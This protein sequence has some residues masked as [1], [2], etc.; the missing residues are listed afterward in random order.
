MD[1]SHSNHHLVAATTSALGTGYLMY[2]S[3]SKSNVADIT[4]NE[5]GAPTT[6]E[7]RVEGQYKGHEDNGQGD[8]PV[9]KFPD[10]EKSS[11]QP[12][13]YSTGREL[14]IQ[15]ECTDLL[16]AFS[17]EIQAVQEHLE[18]LEPVESETD[19]EATELVEE[20]N[21]ENLLKIMKNIELPREELVEDSIEVV[22]ESNR[23]VIN[24]S[25]TLRVNKRSH[26]VPLFALT[27]YGP[28]FPLEK[29]TAF[30]TY[31]SY[32]RAYFCHV[33]G[34]D[35]LTGFRGKSP[36]TNPSRAAFFTTKNSTNANK[37]SCIL[38]C[39]GQQ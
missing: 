5:E 3:Y 36:K 39:R 33:D 10:V 30:R 31:F 17:S 4:D 16:N 27:K 28:I 7:M 22:E 14:R 6:G 38:F 23:D 37:S 13:D 19:S 21:V 18:S 15:K 9:K 24:M 29:L 35:K 12:L 11:F 20:K 34:K 1:T 32:R 8:V 25:P 26:C 2:R